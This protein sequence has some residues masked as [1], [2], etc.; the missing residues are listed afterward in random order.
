MKRVYK[1]NI[2]KMKIAQ[3][4]IMKID[5]QNI[6]WIELCTL[7]NK[8]QLNFFFLW[9]RAKT[10]Q[11]HTHR[12]THRQAHIIIF[13]CLT[14]T[15]HHKTLHIFTPEKKRNV[16]KPI[17]I[18]SER[19]YNAALVEFE[20][21]SWNITFDCVLFYCEVSTHTHHAD[22]RYS[23]DFVLLRSVWHDW[24]IEFNSIEMRKYYHILCMI[25]NCNYLIMDE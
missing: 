25:N 16:W 19:M 21:N 22:R 11:K 8:K 6:R 2:K 17:T 23:I 14:E 10:M 5:H 12:Q 7:S 3:W 20:R 24:W 18:Y 1:S 9:R 15:A 13:G 4:W